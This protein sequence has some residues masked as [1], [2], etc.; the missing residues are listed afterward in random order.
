MNNLSSKV[1]LRKYQHN[2]QNS[3]FPRENSSIDAI[4]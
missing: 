4:S 1:N 3:V 2:I